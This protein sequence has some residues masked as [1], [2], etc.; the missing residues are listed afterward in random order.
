M[1]VPIT[2]TNHFELPLTCGL[3]VLGVLLQD[4]VQAEAELDEGEVRHSL[5]WKLFPAGVLTVTVDM[6]FCF[7]FFFKRFK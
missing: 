5:D 3:L 1:F 6:W 7:S 2:G 4:A